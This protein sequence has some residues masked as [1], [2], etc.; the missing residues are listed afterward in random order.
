MDGHVISKNAELEAKFQKYKGRV[1]LRGDTVKDDSGAHA[2][3]TEQGPSASQR[4]A[5]QVMDAIAR[6]SCDGQGAD[7]ISADTQVQLED[8]SKL[9]KNPSLNVQTCGYVFHDMNGRNH[10][11]TLKTQ[12]FLLN[13]ICSATHSQAF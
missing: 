6:P 13:E 3:F 8:A 5:A 4:T 1:V 9:L 12:W 7:A 11:L 2:V 10:G